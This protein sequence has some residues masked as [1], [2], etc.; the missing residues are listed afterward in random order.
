MGNAVTIDSLQIELESNAK[1]AT[2][3]LDA[4]TKTLERLKTATK[5]GIGLTAVTKQ[6]GALNTAISGMNPNSTTGLAKAI[7]LLRN[8]GNV[9]ISSSIATQL[10]KI[11][12]TLPKLNIGDGAT[13]IQDLVTALKP[14]ETLGK[15]SLGAT[16]NALNK[17]PKA[18]EKID[19][20]KL[21]TQIQSLTRIMKPLADEMDKVARGFS[22]FPSRIQKIIAENE[23]LSASNEKSSMSF[24]NLYRKFKSV[25]G[26]LKTG[27]NVLKNSLTEVWNM[28]KPLTLLM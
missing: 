21:Y 4:L 8:L 9:K 19:T 16:V 15:S 18:L 20:R 13:K 12:E 22:A 5:G 3:G 11:N 2:S 23:K 28:S 14:L 1:S 26:S 6:L 17:L 25:W 24:V 10:T 27:Y 7:L